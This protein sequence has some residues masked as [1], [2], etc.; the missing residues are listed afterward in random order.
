MLGVTLLAGGAERSTP[1]A[2]AARPCRSLEVRN[3]EGN[4]IVPGALGDIPYANGRALDAYVHAGPP[5][6]PSV[7][8]IH[9]GGWNSGSR[10]A[11]VGQLLELLTRGGFN[12]FS[13]DYH[14]G[15]FG[16]VD[17]S[18]ADIRE[19]LRFIRCRAADLGIDPDGL[20]LLGED[21]GAHLAAL[22]A[23][24]RPAGVLGAV[25][26]GGFYERESL[27][28]EAPRDGARGASR[29]VPAARVHPRMPPVLVVH[30]EADT[31][32][33]VAGAARYCARI[34]DAAAGRCTLERVPGASHRLENWWP[35]HWGYK[36][37]LVE[38]LQDVTGAATLEYVP[39]AGAVEK[40]IRFSEGT[41]LRLDAYTPRFATAAPAVILVHGGGWEAGDKVT[42]V[43]P[44]FEPL[45]KAGLAWFSIDYRLTPSVTHPQ[46]M[47]DLREA[48][49]F[50]RDGARRFRID[51]AR[52]VLLGES[53]S[54]QMVSLFASEDAGVAG[55]VSFY[56]VYDLPSMVTD[57][58]PRSLLVRLFRRPV[59]DAEAQVLLRAYSPLHRVHGRM[60]PML[61]VN[62]TGERLWAQAQAYGARLERAGVAV[63]RIVLEGA[64]HGMGSWE[65][66]PEW[67][68]YA[69]RVVDWIVRRT[70]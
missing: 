19:A 66:H 25:L 67:A 65:G 3:H 31:E 9:G 55:V 60:P 69:R 51:P 27:P 57:A 2:V 23:S 15:G 22:L 26:V 59:L 58:S 7:V 30:G 49:R 61:L 64:P 53:A 8:V 11:H 20:V 32:S 36:R 34:N 41:G 10:A 21:S 70:R 4:Y 43:T 46:Q 45:A 54:G 17:R 37:V 52:I 40:D 63:D 14:T 1:A 29:L 68:G 62:G 16:A 39:R 48:V 56:G 24:E 6:R 33:P 42:Y 50:V 44:L 12:W 38:W 13:L 47:D 5:G 18:L 35:A 28:I